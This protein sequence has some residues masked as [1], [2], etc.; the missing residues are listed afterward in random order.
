MRLLQVFSQLKQNK[1][2]SILLYILIFGSIASFLILSGAATY[3]I[4]EHRAS[5]RV[6]ARDSALH[7]AEAG[8]N[9]Y[10]WHLAHAPSD[11]TDGTGEVGPY[12]H[13]YTN[14]DGVVIGHFSL[15]I[16][17][18]LSG[19]SVVLVRSTGWVDTYPNSK[20]TIQVRVGFPSLTDYTFLTN[21]ATNF[22][23][24]TVV[25]GPVH[26]NGEIRFDGTTDSWVDSAEDIQGGGGPKSFWR[27][28]V[29]P[30]DFFSITGD[31]SALRD[32]AD[33]EGIHL[34]SSGEEGWHLVFRDAVIDIY[35]V[36]SRNCYY[37]EGRWRHRGWRGWYWDGET[38]CYDIAA[39]EFVETKAIPDNG[40][41]FVE[42]DVWVD[43]VVD[44]RVTIGAGRFPVQSPYK[45]IIIQDDIT[46][47]ENNADD[48]LG[49]LSQGDILVPHDV[50]DVM[51]IHAAMLSQFGKIGREYYYDDLKDTLTIVGAQIDYESGGWK[52]VNGWGNVI[53]GFVNTNHSYDG[54]LR[55]NPP[56]G[57]PVGDTYELIS[58]EEL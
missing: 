46:Y 21:E 30:I 25:H 18:P 2:G 26:S 56:P 58:W 23:F 53:S 45:H 5:Q 28:P 42:D 38:Y 9:Y 24:T 13:E 3:G 33:D 50:P 37:G 31:L 12:V 6:H 40:A 8:I 1:Q 47:H 7:V 14:K 10:R 29:P 51:E 35:R 19:S 16:D 36:T 54:N 39:E 32:V 34:F 48:I 17:E 41:I 57:F 27:S 20:R 22:S 55:Y 15:E 43:G 44:G 49:L 52:Y 4:F 11:F